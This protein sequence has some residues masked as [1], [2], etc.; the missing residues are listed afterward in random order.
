M[1]ATNNFSQNDEAVQ[2]PA[3]KAFAITP[4]DTN[5]LSV[6]TRGLYVGGAGNVV[7][8]LDGDSASVTF[9]GVVAGSILPIRARLVASTGT[10]ATSLL[11]L[12]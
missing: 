5:E 9:T 10:T 4:H 8:Q 12:V 1:P 3:S 6:V 11:G 2:A 7:V